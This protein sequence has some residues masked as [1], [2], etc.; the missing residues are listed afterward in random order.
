MT[1]T[2]LA[3]FIERLLANIRMEACRNL[4]VLELFGSGV[5][6]FA[7]FL[8]EDCFIGLSDCLGIGV[9]GGLFF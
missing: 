2:R 7:F 4:V 1:D 3:I 8:R 9:V 5:V 6:V